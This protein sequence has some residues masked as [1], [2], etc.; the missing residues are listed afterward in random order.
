M[1]TYKL[2]EIINDSD[3]VSL[4][5][6]VASEVDDFFI[7]NYENYQYHE[8]IKPIDINNEPESIILNE[9]IVSNENIILDDTNNNM[10]QKSMISWKTMI[11]NLLLCIMCGYI[12]FKS[13]TPINNDI[14]SEQII[15]PKCYINE[16]IIENKICKPLVTNINGLNIIEPFEKLEISQ[17]LYFKEIQ[18]IFANKKYLHSLWISPV[19]VGFGKY[20]F[21]YKF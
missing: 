12:I 7:E 18:K 8:L 11:I 17:E 15:L 13:Y 14:G 4:P 3:V 5:G 2:C 6:S 16:T 19:I 9:N 1:T 20:F 21:N 10:V